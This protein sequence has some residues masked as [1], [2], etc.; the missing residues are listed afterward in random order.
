MGK[1][2]QGTERVRGRI[3]EARG[4]CESFRSLQRGNTGGVSE[5]QTE[6]GGTEWGKEGRIHDH[7]KDAQINGK[8]S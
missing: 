2:A 3:F 4:K 6:Q 7:I 8:R 5:A 1:Q